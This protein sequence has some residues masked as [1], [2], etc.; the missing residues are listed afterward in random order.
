MSNQRRLHNKGML[1]QACTAQLKGIRFIWDVQQ[2]NTHRSTGSTYGEDLTALNNVRGLL[3][4]SISNPGRVASIPLSEVNTCYTRESLE[5]DTVTMSLI[6]IYNINESNEG[7]RKSLK[8]SENKILL[9]LKEMCEQ[10]AL[11]T[12]FIAHDMV[13]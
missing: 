13:V 9:D 1:L 12:S 3:D 2:H 6:S 8:L 7:V 5:D 11:R 4:A 10:T